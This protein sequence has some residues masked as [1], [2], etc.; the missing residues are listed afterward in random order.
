MSHC[1]F[2]NPTIQSKKL[3]AFCEVALVR[4]KNIA[5]WDRHGIFSWQKQEAKYLTDHSG[6]CWTMAFTVECMHMKII[7]WVVGISK[8]L[9]STILYCILYTT[10]TLIIPK[11]N[12]NSG[13]RTF[14]ARAGYLWNSVP[15]SIRSE[16]NDIS[17]R[18]DNLSCI[19]Q[20]C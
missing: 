8:V 15:T 10:N 17:L 12:T 13:Q 4:I 1:L 11:F 3:Y 18:V 6:I 14:H 19:F 5:W 2:P 20:Q 16:L 7:K 9:F